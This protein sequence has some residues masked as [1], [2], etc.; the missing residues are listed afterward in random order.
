MSSRQA[1]IGSSRKTLFWLL[2]APIS[3]VICLQVF[4][5]VFAVFTIYHLG[6]CLTLP[7]LFN[8]RRRRFTFPEHLGNLGLT[9]PGT[10]RGL[11]VGLV[12]GAVLA[13]GT[14]LAFRW[15]HGFFLADHNVIPAL[16][17][18][19]VTPA[20]LPLMFWFMTLANAPAEE[21]YWRGFLHTE[22]AGRQPRTAT[23]LLTAACYASY[24]GVT[25]Y[26]LMANLPV[27]LLFM[28]AIL[29]AGFFWGWLREK[30]GSVWPALLSHT[31][32][33]A[34]YMIVARPLLEA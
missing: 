11:V 4:S 17:D 21:L 34:A 20:N 22:L 14:I 5:N 24:H 1:G 10:V 7:A 8:L 27:A 12:L 3:V 2:G 19:G 26:L 30:T 6:F 9:G 33:A 25:V 32:A 28:S 31:G 15:S 13:C 18:W 16:A 29:A 23:I